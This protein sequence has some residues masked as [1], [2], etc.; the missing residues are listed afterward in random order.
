MMKSTADPM[1]IGSRFGRNEREFSESLGIQNPSRSN[2]EEKSDAPRNGPPHPRQY[3]PVLSEEERQK[4]P[5]GLLAYWRGEAPT[6][7]TDPTGWE[8]FRKTLAPSD[9]LWRLVPIDGVPDASEQTQ[10]DG[11]PPA[12]DSTG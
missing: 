2:W 10:P 12:D 3:P 5:P 9:D 4:F 11:A 1:T 7:Y 8:E 6:P